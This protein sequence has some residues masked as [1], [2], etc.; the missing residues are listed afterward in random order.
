MTSN[1]I[2]FLINEKTTFGKQNEQVNL[3]SQKKA[4]S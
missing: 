3:F 1:K 4:N 2:L